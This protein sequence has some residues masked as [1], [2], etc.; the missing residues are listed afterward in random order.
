MEGLA[1]AATFK[2]ILVGCF[3]HLLIGIRIKLHIADMTS[4]VYRQLVRPNGLD[5]ASAAAVPEF[6]LF[7]ADVRDY[8]E[9]QLGRKTDHLTG[10]CFSISVSWFLTINSKKFAFNIQIGRGSGF[11]L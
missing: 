11:S 9:S 7:L 5:P 4:H 2:V 3:E 10:E 6:D 1:R 8:L